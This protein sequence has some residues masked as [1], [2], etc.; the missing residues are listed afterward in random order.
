MQSTL[1]SGSIHQTHGCTMQSSLGTKISIFYFKLIHAVSEE[2][3]SEPD[4]SHLFI[5]TE[6]TSV[7]K[8]IDITYSVR[9]NSNEISYA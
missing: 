8:N 6:Y 1:L 9:S 4:H 5:S 7:Y 3:I 2:S